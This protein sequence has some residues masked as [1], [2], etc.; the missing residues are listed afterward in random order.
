MKATVMRYNRGRLP[1]MG[2]SKSNRPKTRM[3]VI[4]T[5]PTSTKGRI[6]PSIRLVLSI[7]VTISCSS[8]PSSRSRTID[9]DVMRI[10][11]IESSTP[12]MPGTM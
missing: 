1:R 12:M 5:Y 7:G 9:I 4:W 3:T 11:V 8:V 6:L 2:T 10:I